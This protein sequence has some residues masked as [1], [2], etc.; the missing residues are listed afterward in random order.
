MF[1]HLQAAKQEYSDR[2]LSF[3]IDHKCATICRV[4]VPAVPN[5]VDPRKFSGYFHVHLLPP[6]LK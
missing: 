6:Y 5:L 4:C 3:D 1:Q 2:E